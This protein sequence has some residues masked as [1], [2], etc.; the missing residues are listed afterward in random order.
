MSME[1]IWLETVR[2]SERRAAKRE[3]TEIIYETP[4]EYKTQHDS[5]RRGVATRKT[6]NVHS[7]S[8]PKHGKKRAA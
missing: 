7:V 6:P 3:D 5:N 2:E 8:V 4:E 1:D